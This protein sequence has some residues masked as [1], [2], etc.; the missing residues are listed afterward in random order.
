MI[1]NT[2]DSLLE[3]TKNIK[4]KTFKDFD[5]NNDLENGLRDKGILGKIV[6]TG[7][8]GYPNNNKAEADF[9][10]LGI[11]LKVSGYI[12]NKNNT[13]SAKERL[14]LSKIDFNN[15]VNEEFDYSKLLF[16]NK[17]ILIIWYE[18]DKEKDIKDFAI[19]DYQ[20]YDMSGDELI[21]RNDFEIIK[22]KVI[23]GEAHLLSEGDTSYLGACTKG[24]TSKDRTKQPCSDIL[25]MPRAFSLKNAYMTGVLRSI[26]LTLEV[27]NCE[28]K[29]IEEYVF[30]QIQMF[31]GRTQLDIYEEL[32]KQKYDTKIPKN[33]GK[34][35]SDK[36][37]GKDNELEEKNDLFKK[38]NYVIKN[39]PVNEKLYPLE[40]MSF[41]NLKLSEFE[42]DWNDSRWKTHF[43]EVTFIVLCYEGDSKTKNGFRVLKEIK[44]LSFNADDIE[45]FGRTYKMVQKAIKNC[46]IKLLP[47]PNT[48]I[49]QPLEI[50]P[51]GV[52]GDDAYTNFFKNDT[53]KVCFMVNKDFLFKK[54]TEK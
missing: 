12:K 1:F 9:N 51:K 47:Y 46:D 19:T 42:D 37:I 54:L 7:F 32:T 15:I 3:F 50:A 24:A 39:L 41:R 13:V 40:R 30:A 8:Y 31:I 11:E 45:L 10:E 6:E 2:I 20:L 5:K 44:K 35:I 21:I 48:I 53:T 34:M 25:A 28:Y 27:D 52:K 26:N 33:L 49:G 17:K 14:V 38:T 29:T 18:Y 16:K 36:T 22:Q 4:G 43:E 23:Q